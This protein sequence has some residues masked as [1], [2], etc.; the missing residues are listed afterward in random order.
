MRTSATHLALHGG[1]DGL[2]DPVNRQ[3][4][5]RSITVIKSAVEKAKA[6]EGATKVTK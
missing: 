6:G 5:D 4:D 2:P 1:K 3:N